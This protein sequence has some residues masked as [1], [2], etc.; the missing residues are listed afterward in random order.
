MEE[1]EKIK[2]QIEAIIFISSSPITIQDLVK[3]FNLEENIIKEVVDKLIEDYSQRGI[4]I[5][6]KDD[7]LQFVTSNQVS[8]TVEKFMKF[9]LEKDLTPAALETLAIVA[10]LGPITRAQIEILR[11]V[12]SS[13]IL[14]ELMIRGY[15]ERKQ[16]GHNFYYDI[17]LEFLKFFGIQNKEEL[18]NFL[19]TKEKLSEILSKYSHYA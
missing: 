16:E 10:Y 8:E 5:L 17:S 11:G 12:N 2:K 14:R 3:F 15:V 6:K 4:I 7:S 1:I 13:Y 18:P 19:Q 9:Q